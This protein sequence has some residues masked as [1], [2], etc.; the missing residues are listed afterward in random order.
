MH[1]EEK[2]ECLLSRL[3]A[4]WRRTPNATSI[5]DMY[6]MYIPIRRAQAG[7]KDKTDPRI[8]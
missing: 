6:N 2:C 1:A 5:D 4:R 8:P 7:Y 3:A